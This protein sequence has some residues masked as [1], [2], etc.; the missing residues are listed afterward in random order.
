VSLM[1][2]VKRLFL[3]LNRWW[4]LPL[5]GGADLYSSEVPSLVDDMTDFEFEP[6]YNKRYIREIKLKIEVKTYLDNKVTFEA[7]IFYIRD[8]GI[9]GPSGR[10]WETIEANSFKELL[11]KVREHAD[12]LH[13]RYGKPYDVARVLRGEPIPTREAV[14]I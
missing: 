4:F 10:S 2:V 9:C 12:H 7:D 5:T 13:E 1:G 6:P 8:A 11:I 3:R 14:G